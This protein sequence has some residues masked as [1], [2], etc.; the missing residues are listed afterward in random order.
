LEKE[1]NI[2]EMLERQIIELNEEV[3]SLENDKYELQQ[4]LQSR[5]RQ[6]QTFQVSKKRYDIL[7]H[8]FL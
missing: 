5:D 4:Q 7:N 3:Q 6:I 2:R 1:I 8:S